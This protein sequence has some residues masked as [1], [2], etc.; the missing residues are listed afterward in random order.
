M[1]SLL[2]SSAFAQLVV[3][4][5]QMSVPLLFAAVQHVMLIFAVHSLDFFCS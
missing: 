2:L 1:F 3:Y 4:H 5:E